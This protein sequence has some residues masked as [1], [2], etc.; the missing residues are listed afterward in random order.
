MHWKNLRLISLVLFGLLFHAGSLSAQNGNVQGIATDAETGQ[1]LANVQIQ[2]FSGMTQA[3]SVLSSQNGDFRLTV[4]AGTYALVATSLGFASERIDG[5]GVSAG[6]TETIGLAM[7]STAL[8]LN[9]IMVVATRREEKALDAPANVTVVSSERIVEEA[10]VTP[11]DHVKALPGVDIAQNGISQSNV[12]TRGFNNIFSGAMLVITD[13]RYASVPSLRFNAYN[14]VPLT[15]FD[16]ER[17]EVLL[18]PASALY[19]PNSANGVLHII[20]SSP[21]DKPGT[22]VS[23][24]GGER[25][26]LH[27]QFR[28][29]TRLNDMVG[30]KVSGQY[31]RADDWEFTDPVEV[32]QR[33]VRC[34]TPTSAGCTAPA[35]PP[36]PS[37]DPRPWL[38][39]TRDFDSERWGGEARVDVR[40]WDNGELIFSAGLN[41]LVSSIELTG[42][43]GGQAD[44][45]QYRYVQ[46]RFRRDRLFAQAFLNQSNAG[47]TYLLRTG[48]AIIDKSRTMAA[49]LQHGVAVAEERLD[50]IYGLDFSR[51]EPRTEGTITGRNENDDIIDEVGGYLHGTFAVTPT[52][53]V[54][55]AL[56]ADHHNRLEDLVFSPR[57]A[58]VFRPMPNQTI[59][60]T[61]NRAFSTPTTNNLFL[62]I[63]A[64]RV[65]VTPQIGYDIRTRGVPETGFTFNNRCAGGLRDLCMFTPLAPGQGIPAAAHATPIWNG[66]VNA[67]VPAAL[68]P[69]LLNPTAADPALASLFRRFNPQAAQSGVG[70]PFPLDATGPEPIARIRPN[71][72]NTFELGY[73]GIVGD[74]L[75]LAADVYRTSIKDF[76]GPL[77]VET[78]TVFLDP[79]TVQA[80]VIRRLTPLIAAGVVSQQQATDII[81]GLSAIP[82]GTV[83]PDQAQGT[84]LILTYRN[85]G[86]VD[87]LGADASFEFIATDQLS[88]T[89]SLSIVDEDCFDFNDD[90][91]C[92]SAQD[93]ALNAPK[94]KGSAGARWSD[95][96]RGY[97]LDGRVRFTDGF[98]VN[99]GVYVGELDAYTVLDANVSYHL[100]W[101]PGA[102]ATL[103]VSNILD[104]MH[105][106]FIGAPE[107]GRLAILRL[108]YQF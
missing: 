100:P 61:F 91:S 27:G 50:L 56:R 76:V 55:G 34:P 23:F 24:A 65:P 101:V 53:D 63:I 99:S 94:L 92:A 66:L 13:N 82:V 33:Q 12:V 85:F 96:V 64:G 28:H 80:F 89:G 7:R 95:A 48:Q 86:D 74:R 4:P 78:P 26:L 72:T 60:A 18:G 52:F 98:P 20:T 54:V 71:I 3:A 6:E 38:I 25:G 42:L 67:V 16:A 104:N 41:Q 59:R 47:D 62:D 21:L 10:T 14:M 36:P 32:Q 108:M 84:D 39:G 58:L 102:T 46:A 107:L 73:K 49:Q 97:S 75:L 87:L 29:A 106:E 44:G 2:L 93:I 17:I 45:W 30:F 90:D 70:D 81:R 35:T 57:A 5:I 83:A 22:A 77:R 88:L 8:L 37:F 43:G 51:T 11:V 105:Q 79:A 1:P 40:P 68:R 15:N 9:P 69:A 103:T 19:G 31:F